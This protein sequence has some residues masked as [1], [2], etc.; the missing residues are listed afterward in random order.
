[1]TWCV[2]T[3]ICVCR[4]STVY[5]HTS[6]SFNGANRIY[7]L[8]QVSHTQYT[9][10]HAQ[11]NAYK[12]TLAHVKKKRSTCTHSSKYSTMRAPC[13]GW[14]MFSLFATVIVFTLHIV[15]LLANKIH[16]KC[17]CLP[18]SQTKHKRCLEIN[19]IWYTHTTIIVLLSLYMHVRMRILDTLWTHA[20]RYG[21]NTLL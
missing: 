4:Y 10:T 18:C 16:R 21:D 2:C 11:I 14:G 13:F 19:E 9:H 5:M 12:N 17:G 6:A 15:S 7:R 1:M 3:C 8:I 20:S